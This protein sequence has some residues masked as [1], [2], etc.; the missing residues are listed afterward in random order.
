MKKTILYLC[1]NVICAMNTYAQLY[2][3]SFNANGVWNAQ[4][5]TDVNTIKAI[6]VQ[7]DNK[8]VFAGTTRNSGTSEINQFMLGRLTTTGVLDNSFNVD[9]ISEF[10]F[11]TD[12]YNSAD[13]VLCMNNK[14]YAA[15]TNENTSFWESIVVGLDLN[16]DLDAGFNGTGTLRLT[17]GG[18]IDNQVY[19]INATNDNKIIA[20]GYSYTSQFNF[21]G[22]K[23]DLNG[24]LDNSFGTN[25]KIFFNTIGQTIEKSCIQKDNKSLIVADNKLM[26]LKINGELDSTLFGINGKVNLN[27]TSLEEIRDIAVQKDG[28]IILC[29]SDLNSDFAVYR[30]NSNGSIDMTF[31]SGGKV[32]VDFGGLSNPATSVAIDT[33]STSGK[34][35][36]TGYSFYGG[37]S[38]Y[39]ALARISPSDGSVEAHAEFKPNDLNATPKD[40][41][42]QSD[43]KIVIGGNSI[44]YAVED[45]IVT[46]INQNFATLIAT[47][48][49]ESATT[50]VGVNLFP[51]PANQHINIH[52]SSNIEQV[53]V[54]DILGNE[55]LNFKTSGNTELDISQLSKGLYNFVITTDKGVG[56]KKVSIQ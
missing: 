38:T 45:F 5:R 29:G 15:G 31:G 19:S 17:I 6:A 32:V 37:S 22:F 47:D 53:K 27:L 50:F 18:A 23:S 11:S 34:I 36:V 54:I 44:G 56:I 4:I 13:N 30:Y 48:I 51:N 1:F 26:R 49:E 52:S 16:G 20:L 3:N 35:F 55:V 42:L 25:G 46:R 33:S 43:G 39:F 28:K 40:V 10:T 12:N 8:I 14:I 21:S 7:S 2:D 9:G 41:L 24:V